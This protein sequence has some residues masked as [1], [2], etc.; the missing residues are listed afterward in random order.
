MGAYYLEKKDA[1][2]A[3]T[4]I[5]NYNALKDSTIRRLSTLKESD[6]TQQ[7][8]NFE[9][10]YEIEN[11]SNNNKLQTRRSIRRRRILRRQLRRSKTAVARKT[12]F[13]VP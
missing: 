13:C 4:Y 3:L 7:L 1:V 12:V 8:A 5:Q 10:Q 11:L 9:K 2:K 6:V